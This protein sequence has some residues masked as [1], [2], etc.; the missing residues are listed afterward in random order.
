MK[1]NKRLIIALVMAVST[2]TGVTATVGVGAN[3]VAE[4]VPPLPYTPGTGV[5]A[6]AENVPPLPYTPPVT[7]TAPPVVAENV[8]PIPYG[9]TTQS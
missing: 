6:V 1:N 4:N 2:A 7:V 8:P 3:S 5:S 9:P